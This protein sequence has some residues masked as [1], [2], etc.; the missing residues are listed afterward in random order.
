M[1]LKC[2]TQVMVYKA[3]FDISKKTMTNDQNPKEP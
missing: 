2:G 3:K 1:Y